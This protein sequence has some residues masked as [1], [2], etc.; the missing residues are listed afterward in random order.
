MDAPD[1][2]R[3]PGLPQY[4]GLSQQSYTG[5]QQS[6]PTLP[7]LHSAASFPSLY[8]GHHSNPQTP[9]PPHTPV[10]S[11]PNGNSTMPPLQHPPLRPIQPS[12]SSY[13]PMSSAYSQ[14]P[15]L[16][17]A[18]AHNNQL[19]GPGGMG[20]NH[21]SLY[22]HPPVLAN[23]EPE[24]VHVVGQQGRR[25]VLPTHPGRP[26]P[27]AGKAPTQATKNADGKYECPHCNKTYL[28]L[29]HLKRHLLRHTGERPYQ[30][31]LCK[32]TFSRSD[33]LKR[34]FQKCSIR[35]GN[36]TGANHL[37]HAQQ[38]LQ[39]N[40]PP[41]GAEATSYLNHISGTSM[42]YSDAGYAMGM[43]QMPAVA[44]N[45]YG[46]DLPSIADQHS[47]SARTSR[48]NSLINR[49]GS[50][51]EENRRSMSALDTYGQARLNFNDY[52]PNAMSNAQQQQQQQQNNAAAADQANHFSYNHPAVNNDMAQ[53]N[54]PVKSEGGDPTPYGVTSMPNVDGIS[55]GQDSSMWRNGGAFNGESHFT[56]GSSMADDTPKYDTMFTGLYSNPGFADSTPFFDNWPPA[57]SDPL[58]E[59]AEALLNF[60]FPNASLLAPTSNEAYSYEA[61]KGI[62]TPD[63]INHL[64]RQYKHF[65]V[66]WPL[67]HTPTFDPIAAYDGLVL[68]MCCVGAIYSDRMTPKSARWLT[69]L[70]RTVVLRSSQIY[71]M[72]QNPHHVLDP[73]RHCPTDIEEFQAL[74]LLHS[75]FLWHGSQKQRQQ[76][77][78][79][80]F[81]LANIVRRAS[82]LQPVPRSNPAFSSLH[83]PGPITGDEV[84]SWNWAAWV[85]NEKR[86]RAMAYIFLIDAASTIFFNA[87]PQFD[88]NEIKVS[89]PADDAA[90]EAKTEEECASALGL[91]GEAAQVT[92]TSGSRRAKQLSMA[93]ALQV[94]Y[95]GPHG[96]IPERSTNAFG[97]F[98][99]IHAIHVQ[100]FNIQ[101]QLLR[102]VSTGDNGTPDAPATPPN[103][104]SEQVQQLLRS[105]VQ[106]LELWKTCWD[107]DLAIQYPPTEPRLGY[108]RDGVHYYFLARL[109]LRSSR[110]EEW[111]APA[112]MRCR[113][114][115]N[116][117]KQIR[118]HVAADSSQKGIEIGSATTVTDDYGIN[119]LT[120]NMRHLFTPIETSRPTQ[121][122]SQN[123]PR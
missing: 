93:E 75:L 41:N 94:L 43:P 60:C 102:R 6:L 52:R 107:V 66:H 5:A 10:T 42:P 89:L 80:F 91:R 56:N 112:D 3:Q 67:I 74:S 46:G 121:S 2:F 123:F 86:V 71:K 24:P 110:R 47:M 22:P 114:V 117:L 122:P 103:G 25:G 15:L 33:I 62:L 118:G 12:P 29:K 17:T 64:L 58:Q 88:V 54:M 51:V 34:H 92:N 73:N 7:P 104:V 48:S 115:F 18:A 99:L 35:R 84:A 120:L 61:L 70:A 100:I 55:N 31:H 14:A 108:C 116:L 87:Q 39:K 8:G 97:K 82:F 11:A 21:P 63:N 119:D 76:G 109:F 85:D 98:L 13:M 4:Q 81:I 69:E 9:Q 26:A 96:P 78:E 113:H 36:P 111:A 38:H 45:G 30:C 90:W 49:P 105:T 19:G 68:T 27:A 101:R 95:R 79:E 106:A 37:Q 53:N 50:G 72:A 16:P 44:A 32:D 77:R 57:S 28:H 1:R 40:R 65:H 83:E 23:Q 59:K 20:M